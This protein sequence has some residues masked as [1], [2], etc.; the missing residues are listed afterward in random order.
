MWNRV[1]WGGV[2]HLG[3]RVRTRLRVLLVEFLQGI[4]LAAIGPEDG[5]Q[6]E[7]EQHHDARG[8]DDRDDRVHD[9]LRKGRCGTG[10]SRLRESL[11]LIHISEPTRRTPISYA[12]FCLKK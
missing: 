9:N 8:R 1:A 12:V 6:D 10:W 7:E 2:L 11:S 5:P 3:R 4:A